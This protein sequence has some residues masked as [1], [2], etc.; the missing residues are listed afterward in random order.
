MTDKLLIDQHILDDDSLS[1]ATYGQF[2]TRHNL[3]VWDDGFGPLWVYYE[4]HGPVGIVRAKTWED[5]YQC[6]VDE[7]MDDADPDDPD[8]RPAKG[9][10]P[11]TWELPDGVYWRGS[12][13]P[14]N[15]GLKSH[16]AHGDLNGEILRQLGQG[17]VEDWGIQVVIK[18]D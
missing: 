17:D 8:N 4:T 9:D 15:K 11:D 6:V 2:D 12:G 13:V 1:S 3:R 10:D 16:L 5:A 14:S 7:I 18:K